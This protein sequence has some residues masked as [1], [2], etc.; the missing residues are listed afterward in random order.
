VLYAGAFT[1]ENTFGLLLA[2]TMVFVWLAVRGRPRVLLTLYLGASAWLTGSRTAQVAALAAV[3]VLLVLRPALQDGPNAPRAP[4]HRGR[5]RLAVA[6]VVTAAL[7]GMVL[8]LL[9]LTPFSL[10]DRAFFWQLARAG[11]AA[12]PLF[13]QGSTA[14]ANLYQVGLIP[15]AGTYSVH[16]QWLDVAYAAG[17]IGLALFVGL[18]LSLLLRAGPALTVVASVLIPVFVGSVAERPWSFGIN[19]G[20]TFILLATLLSPSRQSADHVAGDGDPGCSSV[21]TAPP[22]PG[23]RRR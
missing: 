8:P 2:L 18:A 16:N 4:E 17:L 9:P 15:I 3:A 11:I 20:M 14:W 10:S 6:A 7:A 22:P 21:P 23:R 13:G 12:S 19:D 5:R 1:N